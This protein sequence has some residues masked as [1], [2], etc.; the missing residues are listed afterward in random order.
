[1][2]M[3]VPLLPGD[4]GEGSPPLTSGQG[5]SCQRW[6][7]TTPLAVAGCSQELQ[8]SWQMGEPLVSTEGKQGDE[9]QPAWICHEQIVSSNLISL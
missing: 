7:P 3:S 8:P 2:A 6:G 5:R 4:E 9:E 1:M